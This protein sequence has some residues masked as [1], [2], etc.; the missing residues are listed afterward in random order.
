MPRIFLSVG[1]KGR[2]GDGWP[3]GARTSKTVISTGMIMPAWSWVLALY[4]LQNIMM[5]TPCGREGGKRREP[6][7]E[8]VW[9]EKG[10]ASYDASR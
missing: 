4:S 3:A 9:D 6:S 1:R 2:R 5:F 7:V 8:P 10:L